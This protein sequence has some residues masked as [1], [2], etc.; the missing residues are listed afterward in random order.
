VVASR[1]HNMSIAHWLNQEITRQHN[2]ANFIASENYTSEAVRAIQ[3]SVLS[4]KYAEGYPGARYYSGCMHVDAIEQ[5]AITLAKQLFQCS[6]ANVQ[7]HSGSQANAAV[8]SVLMKP[9]DVLMGMALS[10][11]G[12]LSHG[13]TMSF[14]GQQ[15]RSVTYG[16]NHQHVMDMDH[17]RTLALKHRPRVIVAGASAYPRI[18]HWEAFRAIC[19]D[20]QA[21][22]VADMAHVAGLV[23]T[24]HH[25]SPLPYADFVTATTHKTL[26]GPR[27][28]LILSNR[29]DLAKACN[30]A[31]FPGIQGGPMMHTIAA[32]ALA[33]EEALQPA[34]THYQQRVLDNATCLAHVF[35]EAGYDVISGGT[36]NHLLLVNITRDGLTGLQAQNRLEDM[37]CTVNKNALP[38]DPHPPSITS[39]IRLGTPAITTRGVN[40][41]AITRLG[42]WMVQGLQHPALLPIMA[43]NVQEYCSTL[44][45]HAT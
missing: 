44:P 14:S 28:G 2:T 8:Y 13:T 10:D 17:I 33:F 12:H 42:Q 40:A 39:G 38:N 34:F 5:H 31:L 35:K 23:A 16:V 43:K 9:G 21:Y 45:L 25:P 1:L 18:I 22:L 41:A 29:L 27:G 15:Y 32:K 20:V 7:P 26:R 4:H 3:S 19:D 24:Q 6:Y 11:G 36:D 30:K 37:L